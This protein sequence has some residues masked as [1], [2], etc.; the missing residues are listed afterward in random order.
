MRPGTNAEK[1]RPAGEG[2]SGQVVPGSEARSAHRECT[3]LRRPKQVSQ[4]AIHAPPVPAALPGERELAGARAAGAVGCHEPRDLIRVELS[5]TA[6]AAR[7]RPENAGSDAKAC[8]GRL[9]PRPHAGAPL[10][11]RNEQLGMNLA[12]AGSPASVASPRPRVHV[13]VVALALRVGHGDE[14]SSE[15]TRRPA[16]AGGALVGCLGDSPCN[17]L[18]PRPALLSG[19]LV[20]RRLPRPGQA[21]D[22]G[23]DGG[24]QGTHRTPRARHQRRQSG[25][26]RNTPQPTR[27]A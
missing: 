12:Q 14:G 17:R 21:Q 5:A 25:Y 13:P 22:D 11:A 8:P 24:G 9:G 15:L 1:P 26:T 18:Q 19:L 4:L 23:Q 7:R 10:S 16:P 2:Q 3:A 6:H 27:A 20:T